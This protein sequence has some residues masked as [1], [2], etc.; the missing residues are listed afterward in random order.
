MKVK[1]N[2]I[3]ML[4]MMTVG[5]TTVATSCSNDDVPA[6]YQPSVLA[7]SLEGEWIVEQHIDGI[8]GLGK[9]AENIYIPEDADQ[10]AILYHFNNDG[11]GWKE[12]DLLKNGKVESILISRYDS[13]FVY[14]V[15]NE[16]KVSLNYTDADG[17]MNGQKAEL[18]FDGKILTDKAG[19]IPVVLNPSTEAQIKTYQEEADAWHGGSDDAALGHALF[20]SVVGEIVGSD[21][22][23]YAATAKNNLPKG[24]TAVAM[25]AYRGSE[26]NCDHGLAIALRDDHG[27]PGDQ[28][29]LTWHDAEE[30]RESKTPV[31][32]GTW[33]MPSVKDWQYM[34]IGCGS[35]Q[36]YSDPT[37]NME[38]SFSGL[39]SK[40]ND[41]GGTT[42]PNDS[43]YWTS[44]F[45]R[46]DDDAWCFY[47][48]GD[49]VD[50]RTALKHYACR[51]RACLAF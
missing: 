36:S 13:Q 28:D 16:G 20:D 44:T 34:F 21:G 37:E 51:F 11:T 35:D 15:S 46:N 27:A 4:T 25:V 49:E 3:A 31:A 14:T 48:S 2:T 12:L 42:L 41:V 8:E 19:D 1:V 40:L 50:F 30:F 33:R 32:G 9:M 38:R 17:K 39:A 6:S 22:K 5:F 43:F 26:S 23:A 45:V 29:A 18:L 10:F 47:I 7:K 24:V